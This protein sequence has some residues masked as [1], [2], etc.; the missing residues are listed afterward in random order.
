M[1]IIDA[2]WDYESLG[3]RSA[4]VN[5]ELAD[6]KFS[7]T[8]SLQ[9]LSE[10]H[11]YVVVKVPSS[12]HEFV[13]L[14]TDLRFEFAETLFAVERSLVNKSVDHKLLK[15]ASNFVVEKA[16]S[17]QI[18]YVHEQVMSGIFVTDR[19][20]LDQNFSAEASA[21]RYS[22]WIKSEMENGGALFHVSLPNGT[23]L[24]FFTLRITDKLMAYSVL[25]G[26]FKAEKTP[27]FGLM[28]LSLIIL[29]A[30]D[31]GARK[32]ISSISSNN[33]PVVRTHLEL[34]F[35]IKDLKYVFVSHTSRKT[36]S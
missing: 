34:G 20:S 27:G 7:L 21:R 24:G 3:V 2:T 4:E 5:C 32:I 6:S 29:T 14:M 11:E 25:S 9:K 12:H 36:G 23:S 8:D 28:L 16:N 13:R 22:N 1:Q 26:A 17:E 33:L 19:I 15:K 31:N 18:A 30:Q 10:S 35:E